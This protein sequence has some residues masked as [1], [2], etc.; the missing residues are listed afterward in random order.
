MIFKI[1]LKNSFDFFKYIKKSLTNLSNKILIIN[2]I[3]NKS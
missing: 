2:F 1:N 3:N